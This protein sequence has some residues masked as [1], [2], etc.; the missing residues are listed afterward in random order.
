VGIS[1]SKIARCR[2]RA[3]AAEAMVLA[4]GLPRTNTEQFENFE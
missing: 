3:A 2:S 4:P 1:Y